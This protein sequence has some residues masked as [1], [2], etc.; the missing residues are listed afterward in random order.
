L[1]AGAGFQPPVV[2]ELNLMARHVVSNH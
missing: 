2:Y 1:A